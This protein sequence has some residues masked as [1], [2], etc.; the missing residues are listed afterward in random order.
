MAFVRP[1]KSSIG[2]ISNEKMFMLLCD[3]TNPETFSGPIN[4][5]IRSLNLVVR[6]ETIFIEYARKV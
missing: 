6:S 3:R 4:I 5:L 1:S 2:I